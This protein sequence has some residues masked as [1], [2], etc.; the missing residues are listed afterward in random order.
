MSIEGMDCEP[1]FYLATTPDEAVSIIC[2]FVDKK[3]TFNFWEK[4][5]YG[6]YT[7]DRAGGSLGH[8]A[9]AVAL[10]CCWVL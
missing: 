4:L 10:I 5:M 8:P 3:I 9:G 7:T 6:S 1:V 2:T